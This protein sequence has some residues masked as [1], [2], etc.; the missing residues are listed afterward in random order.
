M[1]GFGPL[2]IDL[3]DVISGNS[4]VSATATSLTLTSAFDEPNISLTLTTTSG[5]LTLNGAVTVSSFTA[6]AGDGN[7]V[8]ND[9]VNASSFDAYTNGSGKIL[10]EAPLTLTNGFYG[11]AYGNIT[12]SANV[13]ASNLTAYA[14]NGG[15]ITINTPLTIPSFDLDA[16]SGELD[17]KDAV[18]A[19]SYFT[20]YGSTIS[21]SGSI[22]SPE[23]TLSETGM[24]TVDQHGENQFTFNTTL[25][26]T[27]S[28]SE[29]ES[30]LAL[31]GGPLLLRSDLVLTGGNI[32]LENGSVHTRDHTITADKC[33]CKMFRQR[34]TPSA[35]ARTS[36]S[37]ATVR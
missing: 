3:T 13:S 21:G 35:E 18:V 25:G 32:S 11:Q 28:P 31:S 10:I 23:V 34:Q 4:T 6:T 2:E 17:V 37:L 29:G 14:Y 30:S 8:V 33:T 20:G 15:N 16:T 12:F 24:A 7:L 26:V 5:P 19:A 1:E 22:T 9:P 27:V 36:R